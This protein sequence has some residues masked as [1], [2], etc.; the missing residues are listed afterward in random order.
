M[1]NTKPTKNKRRRRGFV[2]LLAMSILLCLSVSAGS[3]RYLIVYHSTLSGAALD[4]LVSFEEDRGFDVLTYAI[5]DGVSNDSVKTII[6]NTYHQHYLR[7]VVLVGTSRWFGDI[8]QCDDCYADASEGNLVPTF[9]RYD[10]YGARVQYDHDYTIVDTAY[11]GRFYERHSW[12]DLVL[13]RIP[14]KDTFDLRVYVD[15]LQY[16]YSDTAS[17]DWKNDLYA[18]CGDKDLGWPETHHP[19]REE[20]VTEFTYL[21]GAAA[22]SFDTSMM[23]YTDYDSAQDRQDAVIAALDSG[24]AVVYAMAT[25]ANSWNFGDILG[26]GDGDKFDATDDLAAN[27]KYSVMLAASCF[28]GN[29][30]HE[31]MDST[32]HRIW[33]ENFLL[34]PHRGAIVYVGPSGSSI[35]FDNNLFLGFF[36][37]LLWKYP[38]LSIGELFTAAKHEGVLWFRPTDHETLMQYTLYGD[39]SLS[40]NSPGLSNQQQTKFDY[41]FGSPLPYEDNEYSSNTQITSD[42]A[43]LST[44]AGLDG[45]RHLYRVAGTDGYHASDSAYQ[46]WLLYDDLGLEMTDSTRFMQ[47]AVRLYDHPDGIG[48]VGV[49]GILDNEDWLS[50]STAS[51][52]ITDQYGDRV[53]ASRRRVDTLWWQ[54]YF[55]DLEALDGGTLDKLIVEYDAVSPESTGRFAFV[56]SD[57]KFTPTW[58]Y[59]P[60]VS[61]IDAV[62]EMVKGTSTTVSV[63][64]VDDDANRG[65]TLSYEWSVDYGYFSGSGR[66]V[67][68]HA[69]DYNALAHIE[70]T[71]Y[72]LG[73]HD[74]IRQKNILI[75]RDPEEPGCPFV[76]VLSGGEYQLENVVLTG[77]E[78]ADRPSKITVDWY[79][80]EHVPDVVDG[81]VRLRIAED[82]QKETYLYQAHLIAYDVS[83]LQTRERLAISGSGNLVAM[84][85]PIT[86]LF[87]V[88]G[89][90]YDILE[91]VRDKDDLYYDTR[92]KGELIAGFDLGSFFP[93]QGAGKASDIPGGGTIIDPPGKDPFIPKATEEAVVGNILTVELYDYDGNHEYIGSVFPRV[94]ASLPTLVDFTDFI[95]ADNHNWFVVRLSWE[96]DYRIDQFAFFSSRALPKLGEF[97]LTGA[98]DNEHADVSFLLENSGTYYRLRPR[99]RIDLSFSS[100]RLVNLDNVKLVLKLVG[101]YQPHLH[102]DGGPANKDDLIVNQNYPNPCNPRTAISF[103][104]PEAADVMLEVFNIMGQRVTKLVGRR[105]NAGTHSFEWDG[106]QAASGV[107][108]Y[109]LTAGNITETRKMVLLK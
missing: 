12:P 52:C 16:Y 76:Y 29:S 36:N 97:P 62:D 78:Q 102:R 83:G 73:G 15:K 27:D 60:Y 9:F 68:Y 38:N 31:Y 22:S 57:I 19:P 58:G 82:Y 108:F 24:K 99:N 23:K 86:P 66:E 34:A 61:E 74:E 100:S 75:T 32:I 47:Y 56:L 94:R 33:P 43:Y 91:K 6:A 42:S 37:Y 8:A 107:Y 39:P 44:V 70:A 77:S 54:Q 41:E 98:V 26:L 46:S 51:T 40:L 2:G 1:L 25:G 104:L 96:R 79:P 4:D 92:V 17:V 45:R 105:L 53:G 48:R 81:K 101:Y 3:G 30:A 55:F 90:G 50:D 80:L 28:L 10:S 64:A 84:S 106:S 20:I 63:D 14:A 59:E 95:T 87:A 69:P 21:L 72:D 103:S 71:V 67:T 7:Y 5:T 13:G 18:I 109:R 11:M 49:N 85:A 88:N 65:D 89:N 35:Q 93:G